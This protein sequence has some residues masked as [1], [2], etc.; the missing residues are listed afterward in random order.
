MFIS[1]GNIRILA[2]GNGSRGIQ[3]DGNMTISADNGEPQIYI[4]ANGAKC[5]NTADA[6]DPHRCMGIKVEKNLL[7]TGGTTTVTNTGKKARLCSVI[8]EQGENQRFTNIA[9]TNYLSYGHALSNQKETDLPNLVEDLQKS[10]NAQLTQLDKAIN[11][12]P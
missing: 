11:G 8:W 12:A 10:L 5:T 6:V 4:E 1:G 7:V 3:T 2:N 9:D